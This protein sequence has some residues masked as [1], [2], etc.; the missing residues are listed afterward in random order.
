MSVVIPDLSLLGPTEWCRRNAAN[1]GLLR[2]RPTDERAHPHGGSM[3]LGS[4]RLTLAAYLFGPIV[5][6][7][8]VLGGMDVAKA[9][10]A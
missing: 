1:P 7:V 2:P 3:G 9:H 8:L 5:L 6:L 4:F 10:E